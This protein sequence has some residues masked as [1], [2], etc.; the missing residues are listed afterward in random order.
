[1]TFCQVIGHIYVMTRLL[2]LLLSIAL[3][4]SHS[5][6]AADRIL[7]AEGDY[8]AQKDRNKSLAHWKLWHLQSGGYEVVEALAGAFYIVQVFHFDSHFVPD[9]F[10]LTIDTDRN[11]PKALRAKRP[12]ASHPT[13]VSCR[14]GVQD[15]NCEGEHDGKTFTASISA[16][17]P[18]VFVPGEFYDL[19]QLWLMTGILR[20]TERNH[21]G[22]TAVNV[23]AMLDDKLRAVAPIQ[24]TFVGKQ[25]ATVMDKTQPVTEYEVW[26]GG[27]EPGSWVLNEL[28]LLQVTSQGLV[29]SVHG[30]SHPEF[31]FA[32]RNYKEYESWPSR[33]QLLINPHYTH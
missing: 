32:T 13:I 4:F 6:I 20:L 10:S 22:D 33:R 5:S 12:F 18:Y 31:G 30:K 14:Y 16:K 3:L 9:G 27:P 29:A 23:Y 2:P 24:L 28:S 15:L 26:N 11:I 21:S 1:M 7:A 17:Q 19:D 8:I 25:T